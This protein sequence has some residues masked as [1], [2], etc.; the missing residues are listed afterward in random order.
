MEPPHSSGCPHKAP[1]TAAVPVSTPLRRAPGR[2]SSA[3]ATRSTRLDVGKLRLLDARLGLVPQRLLIPLEN[4]AVRRPRLRRRRLL[5]AHRQLVAH[6]DEAV[7]PL[8][9][10]IAAHSAPRGQLPVAAPGR[11]G[12]R[13]V[14]DL[15]CAG[16]RSHGRTGEVK[17]SRQQGAPAPAGSRASSTS[18]AWLLSARARPSGRR[19][20]SDL[21]GRRFSPFAAAKGGRRHR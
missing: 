18:S 11:P 8:G 13:R 16:G 7:R 1:A 4:P 5:H 19:K 2:C 21:A 12:L 17:K 10:G 14:P 3:A 6:D 9:A 20:W 15:R